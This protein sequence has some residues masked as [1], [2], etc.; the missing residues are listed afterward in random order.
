MSLKLSQGFGFDPSIHGISSHH[1]PPIFCPV[2]CS[3]MRIVSWQTRSQ[4]QCCLLIKDMALLPF[5]LGFINKHR[6]C[7]I[8]MT[9]PNLPP[10]LWQRLMLFI[11]LSL[12]DGERRE[13]YLRRR[14]GWATA[15]FLHAMLAS[16]TRLSDDLESLVSARRLMNLWT[17]ASS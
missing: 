13:Q 16:H 10:V 15:S 11:Q 17:R 7:T 2:G 9:A 8:Y 5:L 6:F 12:M 4:N 14:I 1:F 3:S